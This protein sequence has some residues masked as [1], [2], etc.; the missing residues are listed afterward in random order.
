MAFMT[1]FCSGPVRRREFLSAGM[2]G[3]GGLCLPDLFRLR[4]SAADAGMPIDQET[5]SSSC[6]SLAARLTWICTT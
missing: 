3:A 5:R 2:L 6:G 1:R 4:A